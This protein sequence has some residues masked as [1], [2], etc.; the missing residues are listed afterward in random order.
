[1]LE[2]ICNYARCIGIELEPA[3]VACARQAARALDVGNVR[4]DVGDARTTD[5]SIGTVFYLYTPFRGTV[6]RGVLDALRAQASRRVIRVCTYGPCTPIVATEP[7]LGR[8]DAS[9]PDRIA[10]FATGRADTA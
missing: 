4:F 6:M 5:F 10:M 9:A 2:A 7:W 1:M 8:I 3:Y